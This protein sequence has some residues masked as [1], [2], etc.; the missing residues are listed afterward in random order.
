MIRHSNNAVRLALHSSPL[1]ESLRNQYGVPYCWRV[2][3]DRLPS[4]PTPAPIALT[5]V[6]HLPEMGK[7]CTT[8]GAGRAAGHGAPPPLRMRKALLRCLLALFQ[9]DRQSG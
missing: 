6:S 2:L 7:G 9:S 4:G 1:G 8:G 3:S 5:R